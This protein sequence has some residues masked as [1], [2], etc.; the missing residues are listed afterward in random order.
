MP[1]DIILNDETIELVDARLVTFTDADG[2]TRVRIEGQ[3]EVRSLKAEGNLRAGRTTLEALRVESAEG[4]IHLTSGKVI[5]PTAWLQSLSTAEVQVGLAAPGEPRD[6][7]VIRM[8]NGTG[9]ASVELDAGDTD[10]SPP[11]I[12]VRWQLFRLPD[13]SRFRVGGG[14]GI[15]SGIRTI[16]LGGERTDVEDENTPEFKEVELDLVQE[17][18]FLRRQV[19]DLVDRVATLEG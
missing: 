14:L 17:V 15:G 18:L 9:T 5:A 4:D 1:A 13:V 16:G 12:K 8:D 10:V 11:S 6:P 2:H 3:L 19:K 7:G